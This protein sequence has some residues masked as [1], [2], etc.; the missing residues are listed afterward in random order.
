VTVYFSIKNKGWVNP[1]QNMIGIGDLLFLVALVPFFTSRNYILFF[2]MGMIFSLIL[3][4]VIKSIYR[5]ENTIPL[6]GY[7]SIFMIGVLGINTFFDNN[8]LL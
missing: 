3:Y 2:V 4:G 6:A 1:F 7:L 8:F 5:I